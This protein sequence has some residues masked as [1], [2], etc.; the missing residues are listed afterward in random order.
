MAD[1]ITVIRPIGAMPRRMSYTQLIEVDRNCF[2]IS[3]PNRVRRGAKSEK[4]LF[5]KFC[6]SAVKVM[7][8]AVGTAEAEMLDIW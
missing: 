3:S 4:T 6:G 8:V 1:I 5:A 2:V 7:T